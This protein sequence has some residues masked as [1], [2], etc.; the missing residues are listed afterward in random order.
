MLPYLFAK[1]APIPNQSCAVGKRRYQ[2]RSPVHPA[3]PTSS[4]TYPPPGC[5]RREGH[6]GRWSPWTVDIRPLRTG[7]GSGNGERREGV[8]GG[9]VEP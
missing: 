2:A 9:S 4:S 3:S 6:K 1:I 7:G 5:G 8:R